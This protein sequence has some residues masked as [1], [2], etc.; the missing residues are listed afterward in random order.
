MS[1][2]KVDPITLQVI[3]GALKTIAEEMGHVLYRMSFSSIIRESQDMGAGLFDTRYQTICES[4]STP[5]HIG[6]IPAYLRGIEA[7]LQ[8][9]AWHEGDVVVHNHPYHGSS[10]SPDLAIII[11]IFHDGELVGFSGNT[12][13]H[14]DIGAATPGLII[15]VGDVYAEGMLMAGLKLYEKGVRNEALVQMF[16]YN[17]RASTQLI[18]DIEAQVASAQLGVKR[19]KELLQRYG[20]DFSFD[21]INQLIDYSETIMR[22]KIQEIPDGEYRA[23]GFL[24]DD[25]RHRDQRLPVVVTVKVQGDSVIVDLTGSAPQTLTAYNVPF[26]GSCK[27]AAFAAFRK[28][29]LDAYTT[30]SPVPSNEGS[31]RPISVVAPLGSIFNPIFPAA[32]EARFTQCN[33]MIDL[34]IK[35]LAPVLPE[36]IIA[37]S[38][39]SISFAAYSGIKPGGD[40]WVF[41]EV[42]EGAYGGRPKSDGPDAIDNLMANTRNNPIEDL[43]MHLPMICDRYELRDDVMP[44][45]GKYRGGIGVV[46]A[47][48]VLTDGFITHESE[49]HFD[50]PWGIFGGCD[51]GAGRPK[52]IMSRPRTTLSRCPRN[53]PA[54]PHGRVTSWRTTR[55][56]AAAMATRSSAAHTKWWKTCWTTSAAW[57]RPMKSTAWCST[58]TCNW[59][60]TPRYS[61]AAS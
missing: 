54:I 3:N 21:A 22:Q 16:K 20:K 27:V 39:A 7:T 36:R 48:R 19:F 28:I 31:F 9:G 8:G 4:E 29:L 18:R 42:N 13:H 12:A 17:S 23:E 15:D 6:S 24:D 45:A 61:D 60:S 40:Y 2:Q 46:K 37:G 1:Q 44:G 56:A 53:F 49:R 32:A 14:I 41:L 38:S 30:Q 52:F 55:P 57:N 47:Q 43:G 10:H 33:R 11:P 50:V 25:G 5:M 59:I 51:G 35:A 26:E 58:S 34:I